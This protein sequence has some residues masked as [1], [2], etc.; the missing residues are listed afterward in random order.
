MNT[1]ILSFFLII[2]EYFLS[3]SFVFT[4]RTISLIDFSCRIEFGG[5]CKPIRRT[6]CAERSRIAKWAKSLLDG[7][8]GQ[9][10]R[11]HGSQCESQ[12][13][14]QLR[15]IRQKH[16]NSPDRLHSDAHPEPGIRW[17]LLHPVLSLHLLEGVEVRR[18]EPLGGRHPDALAGVR[19][20][21]D[22]IRH[23]IHERFVQQ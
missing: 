15:E 19:V 11:P 8:I 14:C 9:R 5:R 20:R 13:L 1:I 23:E 18:D 17:L 21:I 12:R 6:D 16:F 10:V 7:W 3:Q 22:L 2:C 4:R